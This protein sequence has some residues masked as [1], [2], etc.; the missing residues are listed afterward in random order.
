M[1][2]SD[3]STTHPFY[4]MR[5]KKTISKFLDKSNGKTVRAFLGIRVKMLAIKFGSKTKKKPT[6][7]A[8]VW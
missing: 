4:F 1:N 8:K 5:S 7:S 2:P 6:E 3:V